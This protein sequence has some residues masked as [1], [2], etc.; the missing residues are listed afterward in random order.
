MSFCPA[1]PAPSADRRRPPIPGWWVLLLLLAL[2]TP[3]PA[4]AQGVAPRAGSLDPG[5][6]PGR[7]VAALGVPGPLS[8]VGLQPGGMVVVAYETTEADGTHGHLARLNPDGSLA[9]GVTF[10]AGA[11]A[12]RAGALVQ[13][14]GRVLAAYRFYTRVNFAF[15]HA[16]LLRLGPDLRPDASFVP[17]NIAGELSLQA[18]QPDGDVLVSNA[19]VPG[20]GTSSYG[21]LRLR[22]DGRPDPGFRAAAP[23]GGGAIES[24]AVQADGKLLVGGFLQFNRPTF[25]G[26]VRLNAD[27]S[28]DAGFQP[29]ELGTVSRGFSPF[30]GFLTPLPDGRALLGGSFDAINGVPRSSGLTRLN[31]DGS[32]D[33]SFNPGVQ[34]YGVLIQPDGRLLPYGYYGISRL[35]ADG[36]PDASF[37]AGQGL[38]DA[39]FAQAVQSDGKVIVGGNFTSFNNVVRPGVARFNADGSLDEE[40][41][42]DAG[43]DGMESVAVL[44][45]GGVLLVG[46]FTRIN[47]SA[48]G[49]L[50]R[51]RADGSL[52]GGFQGYLGSEDF[53]GARVFVLPGGDFLVAGHFTTVN[54]TRRVGLARLRPDGSLDE[55]F[56]A[57][58]ADPFAFY[59]NTGL[60]PQPDGKVLVSGYLAAING[61]PSQGVVRLNANG[62]LDAG[63]DPGSNPAFIS[64]SLAAVTADGK[65]L[66]FA[67]VQRPDGLFGDVLLLLNA[68]GSVD[69]GFRLADEGFPGTYHTFGSITPLPDGRLLASVYLSFPG[70][71]GNR[72]RLLRF[73][74]DGSLDPTFQAAE[75]VPG[76]V[77]LVPVPQADGKLVVRGLHGLTR[78]NADGSRDPGFTLSQGIEGAVNGAATQEDGNVLISGDFTRVQGVPRPGLAR[79]RG[80]APPGTPA[81]PT[82]SVAVDRSTVSRAAGQ[83]ATVTFTRTGE[84]LSRT[85]RVVYRLAGLVNGTDYAG[86]P[87]VKKIKAG[88]PGASVQ[89]RPR[90][91][92]ANGKVKLTV[93]PGVDYD[94]GAAGRVKV[95]VAD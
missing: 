20:S 86:L 33:A 59:P 48:R 14:D 51:L 17:D 77:S 24:V 16:T 1:P 57:G 23:L 29:V 56:D 73:N 31:A 47:G 45:D 43:N 95:K 53:V 34:P 62:S 67:Y 44:P 6:D 8:L 13:S 79:L 87:V 15:D 36:T 66:V 64:L 40:F 3:R 38:G 68:D 30:L 25:L 93:L 46:R 5:F 21:L 42:A 76:S 2:P 74:A 60:I 10:D 19:F 37:F 89:V 71:Q 9:A 91:G 92:G 26:A 18:V 82:V 81:R 28:L 35:N 54:G 69:D 52:D 32:L 22:P 83:A 49:G 41:F 75:D 27:G 63:Y 50:A 90:P 72:T 58:V 4:V 55:S 85:V 7:A 80:A 84:D 39:V 12:T 88:R 11:G 70:G 61:V 94:V 78:L 65:A